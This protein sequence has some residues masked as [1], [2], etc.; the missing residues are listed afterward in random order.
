[1]KELVGAGDSYHLAQ[2]IMALKVCMSTSS[3]V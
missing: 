3:P 2:E 1:M